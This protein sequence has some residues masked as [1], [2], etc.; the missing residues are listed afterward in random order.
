MVARNHLRKVLFIWGK[1]HQ[2][3]PSLQAEALA[4][5]WAF[6]LTIQNRRYSIMFEGDSKICFDALNH[7]DQTP[8]WSVDTL[9]HNIRNLSSCFSSCRFGW[10]GRSSNFAAHVPARFTLNYMQSFCF[11]EGMLPP[12]IEAAC[13]ED[14]PACFPL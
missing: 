14:T 5:L 7:P 9:I 3:G 13:K 8:R 11:S 10:V 12:A 4:L 1:V 6:H 2:L